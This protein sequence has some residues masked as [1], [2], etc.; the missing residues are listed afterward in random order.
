MSTSTRMA[1]AHEWLDARAGSEKTFEAMASAFPEADLYALSKEPG[2]AWAVDRDIRTTFLDV[3]AL[4]RRRALSLPLMP[5]AW[6]TVSRRPY[7]VVLTSSHACVKG[8]YPGRAA[9]HFCYV[10]S[11]MRY[12]WYPDLDGRSALAGPARRALRWWDRRSADWVDSFAA[13]SNEVAGRIQEVYGREARVIHPPVDTEWFTPDDSPRRHLLA[14]GR[15]VAYKRFDLVINVA[16]QLDLPVI[17]AGSG[18]LEQDLRRRADGLSNVEFVIAPSD[19]R[20]RQLMRGALALLFPGREDF[21]IIPVEAQACG[22]PVVALGT[23]GARDTVRDGRTGIL[24]RD[25][26][27]EAFL[28]AI[29]S[30]TD[31]PT[32]DVRG[33]CRKNAEGFAASSFSSAIHA[34]INPAALQIADADTANAPR[35][36]GGSEI[37]TPMRASNLTTGGTEE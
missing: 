20:V 33:A 36:C 19:E 26:T 3:A 10:H 14:F 17:I 25:A 31:Q 2:V 34:W 23:G 12:A 8:F 7:D 21:G 29:Q 28:D 13:N 11:P 9:N 16:R 5:L 18:P 35:A 27:T 30:L 24:V 15:F 32:R 4:R 6:R 37:R 22:T 1:I